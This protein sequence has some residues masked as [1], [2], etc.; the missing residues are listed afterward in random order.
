MPKA[1]VDGQVVGTTGVKMLDSE[2]AEVKRMY[3]Q[4]SAR[5]RGL[6]PQLL[7]RALEEASEMGA[8]KV[9]LETHRTLMR[10]ALA[11]YE[12]H[13]F[14]RCEHYS[15]LAGAFCDNGLVAMEVG[16]G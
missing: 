1:R 3:V 6:A 13:G 10:T 15:A 4:P 11:M 5:G 2:R 8:R 12:A 7:R 9:V 16:L 14:R